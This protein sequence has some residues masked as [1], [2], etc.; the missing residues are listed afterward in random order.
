MSMKRA[1]AYRRRP[2]GGKDRGENAF[3]CLK[4]V[5]EFQKRKNR[6]RE[7]GKDNRNNSVVPAYNIRFGDSA[8][9][10]LPK[11]H[12]LWPYKELS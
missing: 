12:C 1:E 4:K 8:H 10:A 3:S 9:N 5:L 2:G 11:Y 7:I 6:R